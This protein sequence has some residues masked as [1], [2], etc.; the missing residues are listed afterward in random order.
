MVEGCR[1]NA[2]AAGNTRGGTPAGG[3]RA[4]FDFSMRSGQKGNGRSQGPE[5]ETL[6]PYRKVREGHLGGVGRWSIGSRRAGAVS[7]LPVVV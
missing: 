7:V 4:G 1:S 3:I 2:V 6:V 5:W